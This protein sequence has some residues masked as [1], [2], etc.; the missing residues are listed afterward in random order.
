MAQKKK[1]KWVADAETEEERRAGIAS[2]LFRPAGKNPYYLFRGTDS[3]AII[4]FEELC[5][6]IDLFM[7][8]EA[9]WIA[10]WIEYLGDTE[11]ADK[12]RAAPAEFKRIITARYEELRG[13]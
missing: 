11:T 1:R 6:R 10:S 13:L 4:D 5:D 7:E 9:A 2:C 12:I 3:I 8:D